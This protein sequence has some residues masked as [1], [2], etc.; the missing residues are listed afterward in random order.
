MNPHRFSPA[1]VLLLSG[2]IGACAGDSRSSGLSAARDSAGIRIVELPDGAWPEE[3]AWR[4]E[5]EPV[6]AIGVVEGAP[7]YQFSRVQ[8]ALRLED[9]TVVVADGGSGE[10]RFYDA[11][12]AHLRSVGRR[13]EGPGEYRLPRLIARHGP[14]SLLVWDPGLDRGSILARDGTF[15]RTFGAPDFGG[16]FA[17]IRGTFGDGSML[18]T[19]DPGHKPSEERQGVLRSTSTYYRFHP[20]GQVDTI[21]EFFGG[22]SYI[23][24]N[25]S[26]YRPFS[27][28]P[29]A[30]AA[31][32]HL[33]YGSSDTYEIRTY[34]VRGELVR[35]VRSARTSPLTRPEIDSV[36][37]RVSNPRVRRAY[38]EMQWPETLPAYGKLELDADGNLWVGDYLRPRQEVQ[39]WTILGP[40][41]HFV[42]RLSAPPR[43]TLHEIGSEYVL[44]S[45]RDELDV[46]RILLYRLV[47]PARSS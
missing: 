47:K 13:G 34:T 24:G 40:E 23:S 45:A 36:I 14:D 19:Y 42:S 30:A 6:L 38:A 17:S 18:G 11:R 35:I 31:G 44:G 1:V 2:L 10:I 39:G 16:G 33:H 46:E 21:G 7:E 8:G 20:S 37:G 43:F 26:F 3:R 4:L 28:S 29:V 25:A 22:E 27:R 9:G 41:G 15:G 5:A 32:E 12:G